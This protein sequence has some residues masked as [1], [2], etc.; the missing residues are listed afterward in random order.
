[1]AADELTE[2]EALALWCARLPGLRDQARAIGVTERLDRDAAR[3]RDGGS[4]R[5]AVRKWL[6]DEDAE[7]ARNWSGR[8]SLSIVGF[9]G[10]ARPPV[11][12]AGSY[13]CPIDRCDRTAGRDAQG[14][15]PVCHTSGAAMRP[16]A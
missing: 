7:T 2:A 4:A 8:S 10:G 16:T 6:Q 1:M 3:V 9:P 12:S 14:H 5:R 13:G 15:T 11:V